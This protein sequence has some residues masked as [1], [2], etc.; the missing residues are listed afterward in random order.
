[1]R[2]DFPHRCDPQNA[3]RIGRAYIESCPTSSRPRPA[4]SLRFIPFRLTPRYGP[5][6]R[7]DRSSGLPG[8]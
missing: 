4:A 7:L 2:V 8:D 1:M 3:M 6:A 5:S